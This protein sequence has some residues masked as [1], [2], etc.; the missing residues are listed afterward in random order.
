M[1]QTWL[2]P[3]VCLALLCQWHGGLTLPA[4]H[5]GTNVTIWSED[6][7]LESRFLINTKF[8]FNRQQYENLILRTRMNE[9]SLE[10]S[11]GNLSH[12]NRLWTELHMFLDRGLSSA[13]LNNSVSVSVKHH[14]YPPIISPLTNDSNTR[15]PELAEMDKR[16]ANFFANDGFFRTI[17]YVRCTVNERRRNPLLHI[18]M[19]I[20]LVTNRE[21]H[22]LLYIEMPRFTREFLFDNRARF[23]MHNNERNFRYNFNISTDGNSTTD[24]EGPTIRMIKLYSANG[25]VSN[26]S[27]KGLLD[28]PLLLLSFLVCLLQLK[29]IK[30]K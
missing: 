10:L 15:I 12:F 25:N 5:D 30:W 28:I 1:Y 7:W 11:Y 21:F 14:C 4:T 27:V 16:V 22:S 13:S 17:N 9:W 3:F 19:D 29:F 2:R 23:Y 26:T 24:D 20:Y 6:D 18:Q 8:M